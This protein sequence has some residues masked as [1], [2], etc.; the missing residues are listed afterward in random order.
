MEG[1]P[2]I[3]PEALQTKVKG[4]MK[5]EKL[6]KMVPHQNVMQI[7]NRLTKE[8]TMY[9]PLRALR[10]GSQAK[11]TDEYAKQIINKTRNGCDFCEAEKYTAMEVWGRIRSAHSMSAA[12]VFKTS[13][14][15]SGLIISNNHNVLNLTLEELQDMFNTARDWF[16]QVNDLNP[17]LK[18]PMMI[19]DTLPKG[20][21]SQ[22]HPHFQVW[23]N[24]DFLGQHRINLDASQ[25]YLSLTGRDYWTDMV[26]MHMDLGLAVR[27]G[28]AVA[29]VPLTSHK[30]HEVMII[31]K[32][33]DTDFVFL[34]HAVLTMYKQELGVYCTSLG[35]SWPPIPPTPSNK[36]LP[37][38]ARIASR[39][40]CSNIASDVS[41]L[42][43]FS[44]FVINV[45]PI[46][47]IRTLRST[48][49]K[50]KEDAKNQDQGK[51]G[52]DL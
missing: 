22:I 2:I 43:L 48:I 3:L 29:M 9:N 37:A 15:F 34:L 1:S 47:T 30:D 38:I 19:W 50:L 40:D 31:A 51:E 46:R 24:Q 45:D 14:P 26:Q 25:Q 23:L 49:N 32:Y 5:E 16:Y 12:N 8:T 17:K 7:T 44:F 35:M 4:W 20:G 18:S 36:V 33:V 6:I 28:D 10:P 21:A 42:E 52:R 41:S 13:G 11:Q 27:E 39:G